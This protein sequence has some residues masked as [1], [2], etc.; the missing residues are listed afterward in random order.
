MNDTANLNYIIFKLRS[1]LSPYQHMFK[2]PYS[3][4]IWALVE[5]FTNW[6]LQHPGPWQTPT[7]TN[8]Y[9]AIQGEARRWRLAYH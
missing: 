6:T 9:P 7:I 1:Y 4:S 5:S 2:S 8:S 3:Y